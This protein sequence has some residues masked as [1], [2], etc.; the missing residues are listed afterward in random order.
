MTSI[1]KLG[2]LAIGVYTSFI[3]NVAHSV[4]LITTL[5]RSARRIITGQGYCHLKLTFFEFIPNFILCYL[6]QLQFI[7]SNALQNKKTCA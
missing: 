6:H 7:Q 5:M 2:F 4:S 3:G 1:E